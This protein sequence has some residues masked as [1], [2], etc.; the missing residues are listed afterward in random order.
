MKWWNTY[1]ILNV[2]DQKWR[3]SKIVDGAVE[4]SETL[5]GM[6]VDRYDVVVATLDHQLG[7][8]FERY[9]AATSHFGCNI[10]QGMLGTKKREC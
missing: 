1:T 9:V 2:L 10:E 8:K 4:E 6:E 7:Q 5:L 3:R